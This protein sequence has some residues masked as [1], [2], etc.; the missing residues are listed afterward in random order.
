MNS[1]E[2]R[3]LIKETEIREVLVAHGDN[4]VRFLRSQIA[5]ARRAGRDEIAGEVE[6]RLGTAM[7]ILGM[8]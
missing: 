8:N 4:G 5:E 2:A 1:S 3:R 6:R 7:R